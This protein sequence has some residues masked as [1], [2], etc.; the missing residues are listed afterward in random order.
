M[1]FFLISL[2][3]DDVIKW[4]HF[5][6]YWTFVKQSTG[7]RWIALIP[8][9]MP[10]TRSFDIFFDMRLNKRLSKH[11]RRRW[12]DTWSRSWWRHC[13]AKGAPDIIFNLF[14]SY[15]WYG[16]QWHIHPVNSVWV[17]RISI[18]K[19]D[20][21][22]FN[23]FCS[24]WSSGNPRY[25]LSGSTWHWLSKLNKFQRLQTWTTRCDT[26]VMLVTDSSWIGIKGY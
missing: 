2:I 10:V 25:A 24:Y 18:L 22:I 14:C 17:M 15:L 19:R 3:H 11:K 12:L 1:V 16:K 6:C 23:L 21:L 4:K 5:P 7:D 26:G 20:P 9:Q 8:S 13:N